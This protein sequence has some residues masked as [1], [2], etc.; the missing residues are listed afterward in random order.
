MKAIHLT[1]YGNPAQSLKLVEVSES[2]APSAGE[3]IVRM[4]YAP[5]AYSDLL[6]AN[7]VYLLKP[8][9]PSVIAGVGVCGRFRTGRRRSAWRIDRE[10]FA[11]GVSDGARTRLGGLSLHRPNEVSKRLRERF[12]Q[13]R[14]SSARRHA[15]AH[16]RRNLWRRREGR[17]VEDAPFMVRRVNA[18]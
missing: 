18:G 10:V 3:A 9:L 5:I 17:R 14:G 6:L 16:C 12:A 4:E 8:K 2:A 11:F 1:A 15:E 7:G 13:R